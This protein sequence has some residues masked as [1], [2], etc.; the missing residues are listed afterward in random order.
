MRLDAALS[1]LV[2]ACRIA[3]GTIEI[4]VR[5]GQVAAVRRRHRVRRREP[6]P[7]LV[8][9]AALM[10]TDL[11]RVHLRRA[12]EV[13]GRAEGRWTLTVHE[14]AWYDVYFERLP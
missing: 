14:R 8:D 2:N 9:E 12:L 4:D 10:E 6:V 5:E 13:F 11:V 3:F 7:E 1:H